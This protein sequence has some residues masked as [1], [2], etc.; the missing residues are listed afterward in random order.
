MVA[1]VNLLLFGPPMTGK[2]LAILVIEEVVESL[3]VW[4]RTWNAIQLAKEN[5]AANYPPAAVI[6]TPAASEA[7][8]SPESCI[9]CFI[10]S[11][12]SIYYQTYNGTAWTSNQEALVSCPSAAG[13]AVFGNCLWV[14]Y[15]NDSNALCAITSV[16]GS[17]WSS[18]QNVFGTAADVIQN[19][20]WAATF[21]GVLYVF[22]QGDGADSGYLC[23]TSTED[24]STWSATVRVPNTGTTGSSSN[25]VAMSTSP[26]A[27]A[28]TP[29]STLP[30]FGVWQ[31]ND[32]ST[33]S[34]SPNLS[35]PSADG[36]LYVFHQGA[37]G[38]GQIRYN[39]MDA[40]GNWQGDTQI[41]D[42]SMQGQPTPYVYNNELFV[43]YDQGG[44]GGALMYTSSV[45]GVG[46]YEP[47][48]IS[49]IS[50]SNT[51]A[52]ALLGDQLFC[53]MM[54]PG[55]DQRLWCSSTGSDGE[56]GIMYWN[57]QGILL[58]QNTSPGIA[59]FNDQIYCFYQG[60]DNNYKANGTLYYTIYTQANT[61]NS[62]AQLLAG[63]ST[64]NIMTCSPAPVEFGGDLYVF[65]Q[66]SGSNEGWMQY[67]R[68]SDGNDWSSLT[69]VP[70]T[71][72]SLTPSPVVYKESLYVF[73][74]G[75]GNAGEIWFN[76]MG[77]NGSWSGDTQIT[78]GLGFYNASSPPVAV[79]YGGS[80]YV[81]YVGKNYQIYYIKSTSEYPDST[82][83]SEPMC[84]P[85]TMVNC[86]D[87]NGQ[88]CQFFAVIEEPNG[89]LSVYFQG[90]A[91]NS[92]FGSGTYNNG[93]L[94]SVSTTNPG[95]GETQT[96]GD[97]LYPQGYWSPTTQVGVLPQSNS[98][99]SGLAD[100]AN[101]VVAVVAQNPLWAG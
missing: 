57:Y 95:S 99:P 61:W 92:E 38:N 2:D 28:F 71:G 70:N 58:A 72:M 32:G 31:T 5:N 60:V 48:Q 42:V 73:H 19:N 100:V 82:S 65:F 30:S 46:W 101:M 76:T 89:Q 6:F 77:S 86:R 96:S 66:G 29:S 68:S 36:N 11:S 23:Y 20:P 98:P 44:K 39:V 4:Q 75:G 10:A 17:K 81:F 87:V 91:D 55:Q 53:M 21:N 85:N 45:D 62:G 27:A 9:Y 93:Y 33:W 13:A 37:N 74:T 90:V 59:Q 79:A 26:G 12:G 1:P 52:L 22:Y 54:G 8:S 7:N 67:M 49:P 94:Y 83:W 51:P 34:L 41:S 80:L 88:T 47:I 69:L 16:D 3:P 40:T 84:I 63:E 50:L 18:P 56:W 43:A 25:C 78:A 24:G 97:V 35:S 15:R 14:F 64:G